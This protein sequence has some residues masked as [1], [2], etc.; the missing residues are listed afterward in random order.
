VERF[1]KKTH[2][3]NKPTEKGEDNGEGPEAAERVHDV[4][5]GRSLGPEEKGRNIVNS[6]GT[7]LN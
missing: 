7:R 6:F 4:L 1:E 5:E 3:D 2:R